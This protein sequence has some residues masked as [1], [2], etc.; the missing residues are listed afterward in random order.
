M[1]PSCVAICGST[2]NRS[3]VM[4]MALLHAPNS[5]SALGRLEEAKRQRAAANESVHERQHQ[6]QTRMSMLQQ[7]KS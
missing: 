5:S 3:R 7:I 2:C 4:L 1:L 6:Q